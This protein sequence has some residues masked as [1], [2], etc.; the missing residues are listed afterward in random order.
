MRHASYG[1]THQL[2]DDLLDL[3]AQDDGPDEAER[4]RR[5]AV[6]NVLGTDV[7]KLHLLAPNHNNMQMRTTTV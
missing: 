4:Q 2:Y 1:G 6:D 7:L 3:E 5:A